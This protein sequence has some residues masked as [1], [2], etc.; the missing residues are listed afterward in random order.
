M[1]EHAC[2]HGNNAQSCFCPSSFVNFPLGNAS[3]P[4]AGAANRKPKPACPA[5]W[6]FHSLAS[7]IPARTATSRCNQPRWNHPL[8]L[9]RFCPLICF[10]MPDSV[11]SER[12]LTPVASVHRCW[13]PA[14]QTPLP[15][16]TL[17]P[18]SEGMWSYI[19]LAPLTPGPIVR[20]CELPAP[21]LPA[22]RS[23]C[24]ASLTPLLH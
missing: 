20:A 13:S 3:R 10:C 11:N 23:A 14:K 17:S 22:C 6:R 19:T 12:P 21:R 18:G 9:C 7:S 2:G 24:I 1:A 15:T 4:S 8:A 5:S 16:G